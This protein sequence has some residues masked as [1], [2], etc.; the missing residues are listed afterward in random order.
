ML[1]ILNHQSLVHDLQTNSL[2]SSYVT[3]DLA[4]DMGFWEPIT[5]FTVGFSSAIRRRNPRNPRWNPTARGPQRPRQRRRPAVPKSGQRAENMHQMQHSPTRMASTAF[6]LG[7]VNIPCGEHSTPNKQIQ[8][9]SGDAHTPRRCALRWGINTR[10]CDVDGVAAGGEGRRAN[11]G[12]QEWRARR[13]TSG[14]ST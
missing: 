8:R 14:R 3:A 7:G 11:G 1:L 6:V 12:E 9:R 2:H 10:A 5:H 4:H 13:E